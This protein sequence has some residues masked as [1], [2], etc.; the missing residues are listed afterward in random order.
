MCAM[1]VVSN[2]IHIFKIIDLLYVFRTYF[3]QE[4]LRNLDL[5]QL[6]DGGLDIAKL[7]RILKISGSP[8][9]IKDK[10]LYEVAADCTKTVERVIHELQSVLR[11]CIDF[12][13]HVSS[14]S[15]VTLCCT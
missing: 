11:F 10:L 15:T 1:Y 6:D 2:A 4:S 13:K 9:R 14:Y 8:E 5:H 12:G 7:N 3:L